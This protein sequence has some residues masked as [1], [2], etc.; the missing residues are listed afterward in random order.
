MKSEQIINI[1]F[2]EIHSGEEYTVCK[3][4]LESF[5]EFIAPGYS[6]EGIMEFSKFVQADFLSER[7]AN[8]GYSFV[9]L[10][11]NELIGFIE[12]KNLNHISLLF[13]KKEYQ[14]MGIAK[15]LVKLSIDR[16]KELSKDLNIIEVNSSPY[17]VK[18]Y[19]QMGFTPLDVE[20]VVNGIRFIPMTLTL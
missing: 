3:L 12:V 19:E 15:S 6:S 20:Q 9:A 1:A 11:K 10:D 17:A 13:V 2:R 4:V 7:L 16:S 18:I 5:N 14:K 8:G